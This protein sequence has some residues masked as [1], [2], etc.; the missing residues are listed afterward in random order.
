MEYKKRQ[1]LKSNIRTNVVKCKLM[2]LKQIKPFVT[3]NIPTKV[4]SSN[5]NSFDWVILLDWDSIE[6]DCSLDLFKIGCINLFDDGALL[7]ELSMCRGILNYNCLHYL[8]SQLTCT[9]IH[10]SKLN[11]IDTSSRQTNF[12]HIFNLL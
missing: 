7:I 11:M 5:F 10:R 2:F 4:I 6:S 8:H 1:L 9:H 12:V 3:L